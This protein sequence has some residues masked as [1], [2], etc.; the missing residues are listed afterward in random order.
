MHLGGW[1]R[2]V[3]DFDNAFKPDAVGLLAGFSLRDLLIGF[4][5]DINIRDLVN[6][7]TGQGALELSI[8]YFGDYE[9][10]NSAC[11]SF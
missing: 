2:T 6:Y 11:P 7:P 4:S 5:Y 10:E 3:R 8:S 9:S 1:I